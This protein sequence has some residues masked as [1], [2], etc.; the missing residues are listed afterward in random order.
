MSDLDI[1][2]LS[3]KGKYE[4]LECGEVECVCVCVCL[5]N[6]NR[7]L[8]NSCKAICFEAVWTGLICYDWQQ[9]DRKRQA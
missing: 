3:E 6:I 5:T 1:Y 8:N 7:R 4:Q 2:R 9:A